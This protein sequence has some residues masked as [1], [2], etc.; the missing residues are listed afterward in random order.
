[1]AIR[2]RRS[3]KIFPGVKL[4][5]NKKSI[6]VTVG[7]KWLHKTYSTTGRTTTTASIPGTG[8]YASATAKPKQ[9]E[10]P[11]RPN[12]EKAKPDKATIVRRCIIWGIVLV[13]VAVLAIIGKVTGGAA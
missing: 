11:V 5:L 6:S 9:A 7:P 13:A 12:P 4:N 10:T 1:M 8:L 3:K 2:Y